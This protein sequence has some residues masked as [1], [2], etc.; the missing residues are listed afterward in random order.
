MLASEFGFD[1]EPFKL[2]PDP[3]FL[4]TSP[5]QLE[6]Y[7]RLFSGIHA[8]KGLFLLTGESG[9]GK[10]LL[11]RR[12]VDDL[13][14]SGCRVFF[15]CNPVASFDELISECCEQAGLGGGLA[16][17]VPRG[18]AFTKFVAKSGEI[19]T[20][21]LDEAH[22]LSDKVLKNLVQFS[23]LEKNGGH[24][25]QIV[26][27]GQPALESRIKSLGLKSAP[28]ERVKLHPLSEREV[29][30]F[31]T[32][33]LR[34]AGCNDD[35]LFSDEAITQVARYSEGIPARINSLCGIALLIASLESHS[36]VSAEMIDQAAEERELDRPTT[37]SDVAEG[38]AQGTDKSPVDPTTETES[39]ASSPRDN[40]SGETTGPAVNDPV[41]IDEF[42]LEALREAL[43]TSTSPE[44]AP[45][46]GQMVADPTA[47]VAP[48]KTSA[49]DQRRGGSRFGIGS[50]LAALL[51]GSAALYMLNAPYD[52][53]TKTQNTVGDS[54]RLTDEVTSSNEA[55]DTVQGFDE[56]TQPLTSQPPA[57]DEASRAT[58]ATQVANLAQESLP[59]R[60]SSIDDRIS[61]PA[62]DT[63]IRPYP[64]PDIAPEPTIDSGAPPNTPTAAIAS[65]DPVQ[66]AT[67]LEGSPPNAVSEKRVTE[68]LAQG[69]IVTES[70]QSRQVTSASASPPAELPAVTKPTLTVHDATGRE[71]TPTPLDISVLAPGNTDTLAVTVWG[72]PTG[73]TLSAGER[74]ANGWRLLPTELREL[75]INPPPNSDEDF[76]VSL[77]LED[78]KAQ[79]ILE[80]RTLKVSLSAVADAPEVRARGAVGDQ[81]T[82]IPLQIRSWLTDK[83]G[84]E[85]LSLKLSGLPASATLSAGTRDADGTW[86]LAPHDLQGLILTPQ[87][88]TPPQIALKITAVAVETSNNTMSSTSETI[89]LGIIYAS[90]ALSAPEVTY[91]RR[92]QSTV[93][94]GKTRRD[95]AQQSNQSR[96]GLP[97][98]ASSNA[99]L[100][101][102]AE[103]LIELGNYDEARRL[104]ERAAQSGDARAATALGKTYDPVLR[105]LRK[106]FG[107][108]P[109][110]AAALDWYARAADAG[111]SEAKMRENA[112]LDWL[113]Q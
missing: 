97:R 44:T 27:S 87:E 81:Y 6:S 88:N 110:V 33:Q 103:Q 101:A 20:L 3:K 42:D 111:S 38:H 90:P 52:F 50:A 100:V 28:A 66:R 68:E 7:S 69:A 80:N 59:T 49:I 31:V 92:G 77:Q 61:S 58:D 30:P 29:G 57:T 16:G 113:A 73:A 8:R 89:N 17:S 39:C 60:P 82:A 67:N 84:S 43:A 72:L 71:D 15:F 21:L 64:K 32:Q 36:R 25:L 5:D 34:I 63:E 37:D 95:W 78:T 46:S 85:K 54:V 99:K 19:A 98:D 1:H 83:D 2:T 93:A 41:V 75:T 18:S 40:V 45:Q 47:M 23:T 70:P 26:L 62:P 76:T 107:S 14:A 105:K 74:I 51:A 96:S 65:A 35:Q 11:L 94:S 9:T 12:M 53:V 79:T 91:R 104:L 56:R 109:D 102:R 55:K 13:A 108:P 112:L 10:T 86:T 22:G 48:S 4:Y 106:Q 24:L